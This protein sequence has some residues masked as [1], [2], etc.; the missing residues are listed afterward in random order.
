M[1]GLYRSV[2]MSIAGSLALAACVPAKA[3]RDASAPEP[4]QSFSREMSLADRS[5]CTSAGGRIERRGR[6]GAELCVRP[7]ADAGK[8]CTDSSQC[9]GK[10]IGSSEQA[11]STMP[12]SGQCQADDRLFG[13]HSEISQGKAV[14][15]ICID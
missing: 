4:S 7:F 3:P 10:C 13:C 15:T 9:E 8:Q 11:S 12:V 5:A 1:T 2:I 6:I 14:N